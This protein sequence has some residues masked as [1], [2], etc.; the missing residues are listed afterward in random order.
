LNACT[1]NM[2]VSQAWQLDRFE[3]E[4]ME[5]TVQKGVVSPKSYCEVRSSPCDYGRVI[6]CRDV[7]ARV[8]KEK[9]ER[10][11]ETL[12]RQKDEEANDF[13]RHEVKNG[14][15]AGLVSC[16]RLEEV[17]EKADATEWQAYDTEFREALGGMRQ[18][19]DQTL[20]GVLSHTLS[21]EITHGTYRPESAPFHVVELLR[22]T[23]V[24]SVSIHCTPKELPLISLDARLLQHIYH[25]ALSNAV[26]Y[27][28]VDSPIETEV[29]HSDNTLT[30][31]VINSPGAEH[32]M[33]QA[34]PDPNIVFQKR[35]QLH[36]TAADE[37]RALRSKGDGAWVMK[38]CCKAMGGSCSISFQPTRTVLTLS[39]PAPASTPSLVYDDYGLNPEVVWA[40]GV[41][42]CQFQ[43]YVMG[44]LF[45]RT[46]GIHA[47]RALVL[48][49]TSKQLQG[50]SDA[51]VER[52]EALPPHA[53]LIAVVDE[54]LAASNSQGIPTGS[55]AVR[56]ARRRLAPDTEARLLA[57]IRSA[58]DSTQDHELYLTCAH[59]TV[60][61]G[62]QRQ[63][64]Q[65]ILDAAMHRFGRACLISTSDHVGGSGDGPQL[66]AAVSELQK[67]VD[68]IDGWATLLWA[69]VSAH[70]HRMKGIMR[71][72]EIGPHT[73]TAELL[74]TLEQLR[75]YKE[76]PVEF[77]KQW[78]DLR[79]R[80]Q[81]LLHSL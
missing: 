24:E 66:K 76:R 49:E 2:L 62:S 12:M 33:L 63:F 59:G 5:P 35:V 31:R 17:H 3:C 64:A 70:L 37:P 7:T 9:L 65:S 77:G 32:S 55:H 44:L 53:F 6:I 60:S 39:F 42:D 51:I 75:Q 50:L 4:M 23:Q 40:L 18:C 54:H 80:V 34:L 45:T 68:S 58:N 47:D 10:E 21:I 11:F 13:T 46:L 52:M 30:L 36:S 26:R 74:K 73:P 71:V 27:G 15:L 81:S 1:L 67:I 56:E 48:G 16:D 79:Q 69:E 8:L 57:L 19:L 22:A 25:N 14:V 20:Q 43:R 78:D 29:V 28:A 61:K 41:D 38:Q 72:T